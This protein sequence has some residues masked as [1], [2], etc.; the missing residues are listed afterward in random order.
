METEADLR[1]VV[2]AAR[3]S[4]NQMRLMS[5]SRGKQ[6]GRFQSQTRLRC[7]IGGTLAGRDLDHGLF[8]RWLSSG[9]KYIRGD[10]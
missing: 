6:V 9:K 1:L 2:R 3:S 4:T 5:L 10:L 8:F 7:E